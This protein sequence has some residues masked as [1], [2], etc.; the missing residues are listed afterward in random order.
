MCWCVYWLLQRWNQTCTKPKTKLSI[1]I[2]LAFIICGEYYK[3]YNHVMG[4]L[5]ISHFNEKQWIRVIEWIAPKVE[6]TAKSSVEQALSGGIGRFSSRQLFS[7]HSATVGTRDGHAAD[8][9]ENSLDGIPYQVEFHA[10]TRKPT[11]CS[12]HKE[13]EA[14]QGGCQAHLPG[15]VKSIR[16]RKD[17]TETV[18]GGK[19]SGGFKVCLNL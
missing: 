4:G 16:P 6:K 5:G 19:H 11:F 12:V 9:H 18:Q 17:H 1:Y 13:P 15:L 8:V 3:N 10:Q 7:P 2:L 14:Q